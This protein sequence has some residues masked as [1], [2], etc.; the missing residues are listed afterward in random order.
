M[1]TDQIP[2]PVIRGQAGT[3]L[4]S[5]IMPDMERMYKVRLDIGQLTDPF[6][7]QMYDPEINGSYLNFIGNVVDCVSENS[8]PAALVG[9]APSCKPAS[10]GDRVMLISGQFEGRHGVIEDIN[11][12]H[13]TVVDGESS[14]M[15]IFRVKTD[16][17]LTI[18]VTDV[19]I[20]RK[21]PD[22]QTLFLIS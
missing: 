12:S 3:V 11:Y 22:R 13:L 8:Q 20:Q 9:D 14:K 5:R 18:Q 16:N 7:G 4:S 15:M 2:L 21:H 6:D 1:V 19:C 17:G 10:V